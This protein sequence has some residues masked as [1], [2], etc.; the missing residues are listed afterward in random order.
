MFENHKQR[1]LDKRVAA[2]AAFLDRTLTRGG[3]LPHV[4]AERLDLRDGNTCM[5]GQL[6]P[7]EAH[8]LRDNF[9]QFIRSNHMDTRRAER[10]GFYLTPRPFAPWSPGA[11]YYADL[12][13]AWKRKMA[14]LKAEDEAKAAMG[15]PSPIIVGIP[16]KKKQH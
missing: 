2:G 6:F 15:V 16:P 9:T 12:T 4:K 10:L 7:Q 3:W 8:S 14:A 5:I 13:G 11:T 1:V